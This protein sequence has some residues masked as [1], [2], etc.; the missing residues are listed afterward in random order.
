MT[1]KKKKAPK[2][3]GEVLYVRITPALA[4]AIEVERVARSS[5]HGLITKAMT[6]R[7]LLTEMT[8]RAYDE[9]AAKR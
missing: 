5:V 2:R 1:T 8:E 7:L 6:V 4:A 9:R 3:R